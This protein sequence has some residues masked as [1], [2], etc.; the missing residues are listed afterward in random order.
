M[1]VMEVRSELRV[2]FLDR[3]KD[4]LDAVGNQP[5]TEMY[6]FDYLIEMYF[7]TEGDE[8]LTRL[9][10]V[11]I[12][13]IGYSHEDIHF[14]QED[15]DKILEN[16]LRP[17]SDIWFQI[18]DDMYDEMKA[19]IDPNT[20]NG[21][22]NLLTEQFTYR[23]KEQA[24]EL[25]NHRI[26]EFYDF[27]TEFYIDNN[28]NENIEEGQLNLIPKD[29]VTLPE[30]IHHLYWEKLDEIFRKQENTQPGTQI[31]LPSIYLPVKTQSYNTEEPI[32]KTLTNDIWGIVT[33]D[34][35][36]YR[37]RNIIHSYIRRISNSAELP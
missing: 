6:L 4:Y 37:L 32:H 23:S 5:D 22:K 7:Q 3:V 30:N 2:P 28:H 26:Q 11:I 12:E 31:N 16:I 35:A 20:G 15:K 17:L 8:G 13:S 1:N 36:N 34:E 21:I 9:L 14:S 25:I 19:A 33:I 18:R 29:E 27:E 10:N 24:T